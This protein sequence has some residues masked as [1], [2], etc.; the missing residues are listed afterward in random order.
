MDAVLAAIE[1]WPYARFLRTNFYAY[2]L[3]RGGACADRQGKFE[4]FHNVA[5]AQDSI[6]AKSVVAL[7]REAG[8]I[9]SGYQ[10]LAVW[11]LPMPMQ[12]FGDNETVQYRQSELT[13]TRF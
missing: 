5:F 10:G 11:F 8:V 1:Q 12:N 9:L 3:A 2:P 7:A 6:R 13:G 4:A